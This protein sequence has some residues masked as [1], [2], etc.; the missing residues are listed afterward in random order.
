MGHRSHRRPEWSEKYSICLT[1]QF[2][3]SLIQVVFVAPNFVQLPSLLLRLTGPQYTPQP[4][5]LHKPPDSV[6]CRC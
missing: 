4:Q 2:S 3:L 6:L 1:L 5:P